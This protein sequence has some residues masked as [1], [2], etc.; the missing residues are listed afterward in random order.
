MYQNFTR[1]GTFQVNHPK[2]KVFPLL[3]PKFEEKWIPG[4]R[5][6]VIKSS[7][8]FNEPG[9]IFRTDGPFGCKMYWCTQ[10]YDF[11][12]GKVAFVNFGTDV[13]IFNFNID[14][15]KSGQNS[16]RL[17]FTHSFCPISDRGRDLI[18]QFKNENFTE[19]LNGLAQ[20]MENYL[21]C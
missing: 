20:L 10:A 9:A 13:F 18:Q 8:G 2:S 7:S 12:A 3:C 17:T 1:T 21:Q 16:C 5:C 4:W 15:E 14:V 11:I 6:D 19:R